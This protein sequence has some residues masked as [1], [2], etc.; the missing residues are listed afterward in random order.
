[1]QSL[2]LALR[3]ARDVFGLYFGEKV[4]AFRRLRGHTRSRR[5]DE[6]TQERTRSA[7]QRGIL[8]EYLE[9]IDAR[10]RP[11]Y[12]PELRSDILAFKQRYG[13]SHERVASR[14]LIDRGTVCAWN[15]RADESPTPGLLDTGL[16]S[17]QQ[18]VGRALRV[19]APGLRA[20]LRSRL[21]AALID[22]YSRKTLARRLFVGQPSSEE[23]AALLCQAVASHG[24]PRHF[25][26]DAGGRFAGEAFEQALGEIDCDHRVSGVGEKGSIAIIERLWR[27]VKE[28][29]DV[30][31]CPPLIPELFAERIG[32]VFDWYDRLRPHQALG[33]A[34]PA[35]IFSGSPRPSAKPAP[36]GRVGEATEP[37]GI[38]IRFALPGERRLPYLGRVA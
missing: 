37:L 32:V 12:T 13:L 26:S 31:S 17:V 6:R 16:R 1:V 8:G 4:A 35:E 7:E 30:Q 27:T 20:R 21:L 18:A 19:I 36:R 28:A 11:R 9:S 15:V 33:S 14:F 10:E 5:V 25:V 3:E 34:T 29:L 23:T 38:V 24:R 2:R 22:V